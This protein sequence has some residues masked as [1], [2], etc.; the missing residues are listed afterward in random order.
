MLISHQRQ[1][2]FI[3]IYKNAGTSISNA[4]LSFTAPSWQLKTNRLWKKLGVTYLDVNPY[5]AHSTASELI[6]KIG[7]Y[8][9]DKYFSF[10]IVRNP[11]DWQVSLYTFMRQDKN[12]YQHELAQS[13]RNFDEYLNWRCS[14]EVHYQKDFV[15][16]KDGAQLVDFIGRY[17]NLERDFSIICSRIGVCTSLPKL[18]VSKTRH[19]RTY[20]NDKTVQMVANTFA[21]DIQ[22]FGHDF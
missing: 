18:N 12:H 17:E 7:P 1:F 22:L 20:Y 5:H 19:Y 16:S 9:F 4:L 15:Y 10:A 8:T 3:H 21:P 11:W 2:I 14:Y 6:E 13:F